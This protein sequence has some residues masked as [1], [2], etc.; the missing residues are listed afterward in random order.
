M[1]A[2]SSSE[3]REALK[4]E[5][6]QKLITKIDSSSNPLKVKAHLL[7][8]TCILF[9][10]AVIDKTVC[11]CIRN[12]MKPWEKKLSACSKTRYSL[13][14]AYNNRL[15]PAK[16]S[17]KFLTLLFFADSI[18]PFQ[19]EMTE[20]NESVVISQHPNRSSRTILDSLFCVIKFQSQEWNV[21]MTCI[22]NP[23]E[24]YRIQKLNL[25]CVVDLLGEHEPFVLLH[26]PACN[27]TMEM[28][29]LVLTIHNGT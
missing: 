4:D 19:E 15:W 24:D 23:T 16:D 12:S 2:A 14:R 28:Y 8:T 1:L 6:L 26:T 7:H 10:L 20:S 13:Q 22:Y 9:F 3:I 5:S 25:T 17:A 29:L 11:G 18:K 27:N 21:H